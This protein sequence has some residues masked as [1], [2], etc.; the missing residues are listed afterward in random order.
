MQ[1]IIILA[2]DSYTISIKLSNKIYMT[3]TYQNNRI[4]K[5]I[6]QVW[7]GPKNKPNIYINTWKID[8]IKANPDWQYVLWD[9]TYDK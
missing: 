2:I 6:H 5:I 7:I 9:E 1:F 4:P 3:E 8:Y